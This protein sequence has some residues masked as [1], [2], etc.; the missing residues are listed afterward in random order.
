MV[1]IVSF[2][3]KKLRIEKI[4]LW[5]LLHPIA[6]PCWSSNHDGDADNTDVFV[7]EFHL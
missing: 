7:N 1:D 5:W 6:S 3:D 2:A 4:S